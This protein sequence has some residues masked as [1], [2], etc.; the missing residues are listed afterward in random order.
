MKNLY[1]LR[2]GESVMNVAQLSSGHTDTPLTKKGHKQA[3]EAG[4]LVKTQGLKF[5]V[6]LSSPLQRAHNTA[7]HVATAIDYPIELIEILDDL[8]ERNFGDLDSKNMTKDYGIDLA[9]YYANPRSADHIP[10]IETIEQLH[11]RAEKVFEYLKSRPEEMIL[12]VGH[13]A[14][15][16]SLQRVINNQ[17]FDYPIDLSSNAKIIK[18]I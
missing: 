2:H 7:K 9:Y 15:L 6:I 5:D 12:V 18:L 1:F 10:N 11:K 8:K 17:P 16:R 3:E 14:F 4:K 13:G